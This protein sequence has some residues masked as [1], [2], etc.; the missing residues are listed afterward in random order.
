MILVT[1]FEP[2]AGL[3]HNP[4]AE[5]PACGAGPVLRSE[6]ARALRV[7]LSELRP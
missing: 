3:T 5:D 7:I 6:Q 1:G 2:F 4:S